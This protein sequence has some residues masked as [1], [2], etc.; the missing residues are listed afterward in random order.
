MDNGDNDNRDEPYDKDATAKLRQKQRSWRVAMLL[1]FSLLAHNF[2]EGLCVAASAQE[3]PQL[4]ITVAIGIFIHN[5][6]EGIA[7]SVPC[8]AARPDSPWLAFW[9]AS[10]SG[11]AEPIGAIV[12]LTVLHHTKLELENV[13]ASVAGVMCMVAVMELYPEAIR[14]L[15]NT[16]YDSS[17]NV[18]DAGKPA[19]P[20]Y[21]SIL[22]GTIMG[23]SMMVATEWWLPK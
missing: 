14:Q 7:I 6:P 21:R 8:M 4:G 16:P 20:S 12:A 22:W 19:I 1:F 17:G 10:I 3:S 2:P 15:D 13:L 23:T 18:E 11:L 5:V 9:L